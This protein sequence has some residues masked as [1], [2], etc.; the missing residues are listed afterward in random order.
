MNTSSMP[1]SHPTHHDWYAAILENMSLATP[2]STTSGRPH[3][4][5]TYHHALTGF[6]A[7]LTADELRAIEGSYGFVAAYPDLEIKLHTT[8]TPQFLYLNHDTGLWP[9]SSYGDGV[10]IGVIDSGV[11]SESPSFNDGGMS[12]APGWWNGTCELGTRCNWKL[13]GARSFNVSSSPADGGSARDNDGHGTLV[14]SVAAGAPVSGASFF[15]YANGTAVGMAPRAW[16]SV[17][18]VADARALAAFTANVLAAMDAAIADRVDVISIAM[19]L[20][21]LVPLYKDPFAI[22]SFSAMKEGITV[23]FSAG[24]DGPWNYTVTNAFPWAITVGGSSVDRS[25]TGTLTVYGRRFTGVSL[26]P[27]SKLLVDLP[28]VYNAAISQCSSSELISQAAAGK[29]VVCHGLGGIDSL[30]YQIAAVNASE[31]A[32]AVF[33]TDDAL[34]LEVGEFACPAIALD[35]D[36]GEALLRYISS[37]PY[38]TASMVFQETQVSGFLGPVIAAPA[39]GTYS[40]RGP[41]LISPDILKPDVVAPGTRILGAWPTNKP[42]ATAG[43]MSL[44]SP[45]AVRSGT[46]LASAHVAGIAALLQGAKYHSW[47]PAAIR[48][49]MMTTAYQLDNT[50]DP[51]K[52]SAANSEA[53]PLGMGAGH[54]DPNRALH[55]GL[56]YDAGEA[57]YVSFLCSQGFSQEQVMA[58]V[59]VDSYDCSSPSPH[60]NYPSFIAFFPQAQSPEPQSFKRTVTNVDWKPAVYRAFVRHPVGFTVTVQPEVLVF[61]A[62]TAINTADFVLTIVQNEEPV[63]MVSSGSL[64]WVHE[65]LTYT[66]RSPIVVVAETAP[67]FP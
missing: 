22:A 49:A 15:G 32:A 67:A 52:D 8:R 58:I 20:T 65:E 12:P 31:A 38:P 34:F 16:I 48:S 42:A 17:Y 11:W 13:I 59:G 3:L 2:D 37:L 28:L 30:F 63:A 25:L 29:I 60:L 40:S 9:S 6:A 39:I 53:T 24:N 14:A 33:V 45:F 21:D 36:T 61:N 23:V 7:A 35:L 19:G 10:V 51:I 18:E 4:L 64:T 27:V 46:S 43:A 50:G 47:S 62:T 57:D 26:Y 55:P 44:A 1:A 66:V 54:V 5:H 41:S 56:V